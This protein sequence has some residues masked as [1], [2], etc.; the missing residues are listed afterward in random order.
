[1]DPESVGERRVDLEGLLRL[2]HLL[3][4]PLVL[5]R[6]HVVEAVGKLD[7][8][9]PHVL[10]HRDDHLAVV[11]GL[12]LLAALERGPRQLGD[13]LDELGDLG[14]ELGADVVQRGLRVLDDI[15][16]QRRGDRLTVETEVRADARDAPRVVDEILPGAAHL[17]PVAALRDGERTPDEV[18]VD[19]RVVGL[20]PGEKLLHEA[21]VVLLRGDDRGGPGAAR[22]QST[23][24]L[25]QALWCCSAETTVMGSVYGPG[26]S[27]PS[28]GR[29]DDT[30]H[31][32]IGRHAAFLRLPRAASAP[33]DAASPRGL[34]A[35]LSCS[36]A[37][38]EPGAYGA[39]GAGSCS[40]AGNGAGPSSSMLSDRSAT[41]RSRS[42]S[43][44][45]D[46]SSADVTGSVSAS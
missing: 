29:Y 41:A 39:A 21:L 12:G 4:L 40:S 38:D 24:L 17:P 15:V 43:G 14:T 34:D 36:R 7:Q 8:D 20:D 27:V 6:P 33:A 37:A 35:A 46:S 19:V 18:A 11:L 28:F 31:E 3:L 26:V 5:D 9:D 2:L 32:P 45:R 30:S 22:A 23:K 10:G 16:E 1:M 13:A 44:G 25:H 42:Q